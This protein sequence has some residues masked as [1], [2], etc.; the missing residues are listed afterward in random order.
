M[1]GWGKRKTK[2]KVKCSAGANAKPKGKLNAPPGLPV[3]D[4]KKCKK[5][6]SFDAVALSGG[7]FYPELA[8]ILITMFTRI[9]NGVIGKRS[10]GYLYFDLSA[11]SVSISP[12]SLIPGSISRFILCLMLTTILSPAETCIGLSPKRY[13]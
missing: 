12:T 2:K 7:F 1:L 6:L 3:G 4:D 9:G 11:A 5:E 8:Y 10:W 13:W